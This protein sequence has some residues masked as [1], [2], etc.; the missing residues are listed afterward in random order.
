MKRV[1]ILC[2]L[3]LGLV[4]AMSAHE[5]NKPNKSQ[6]PK[7]AVVLSGGG[8]KGTAHI[9]VLKVLERAGIPISIITGTSMGSIV[10]GVYACGHHAATLDSVVR[11]QDWVQLLSNKEERS[12][13]L[14]ERERQNT[15]VFSTVLKLSKKKSPPEGG[16]LSGVQISQLLE[17]LTY[18]YNDSIDFNTLPIKFACVA[19]NIADN[20]EHVFHSGVLSRAMRASMAIPG[21]FSPVRMGNEVLVDGGLKNNYPADIARQMGADIIIGSSVQDKPKTADQLKSTM[22][23]LMQLVDLNFK[24]K[25][26]NMA[27]TDI[28]IIVDVEGYGSASFST[29]AIDT[30]IRRG[31]E[32][33]MV[34]WDELVALAKRLGVNRDEVRHD[35]TVDSIPPLAKVTNRRIGDPLLRVGIR[36]DIEELV[37]LQTNAS[38]PFNAKRVMAFDLTLRLGRRIMAKGEWTFTPSKLLRSTISYT[39]RRNDINFYEYGDRSYNLTY[40]RQ[41][42]AVMPLN[43]NVKNF[44]F[45]I[46]GVWDH[47][48]NL[49]LLTDGTPEHQLEK[50]DNQHLFSYQAQVDYNSEND[51][52][53]PVRGSKFVARYTYY[54]DNL[55]TLKDKTGTTEVGAMWRTNIPLTK[56]LA[57]Q[58][59]FYGRLLHGNHTPLMLQNVIGGQ[60]FG[61]YLEQQL[62]FAGIGH[63]E[64]DYDK[65]VAAQL[66]GQFML[67]EKNIIQLRL[68]TAQSADQYE[69]LFRNQTMLG[70]SLGYFYHTLSGPLGAVLGYSNVTKEPYFYIN[71]GYVF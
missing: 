67:T 13:S 15:Y 5:P 21:V 19:T 12:Q 23:I 14:H 57:V 20:T 6:K 42:V 41:T 26:E 63:V 45:S 36:F 54:T 34:H 43:F 39:F 1:A 65:F 38:L 62:P 10:G 35:T 33:A 61:F 40:N 7:V 8:A 17:R 58:P 44:N 24:N 66:Q 68:A 50:P 69:R 56:K 27:I 53:F 48:F 4:L 55:V 32:A 28:P 9:G 31:E 70:A 49:N 71:L 29:A 46:G 22:D 64:F 3:M 2:I 11:A 60:W 25:E 59:M 52:Y 18:P 51:W 37:A 30:L 16:L 47:Y